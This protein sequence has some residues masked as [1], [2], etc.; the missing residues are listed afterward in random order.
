M[1]GCVLEIQYVNAETEYVAVTDE[2]VTGFDSNFAGAKELTI[3]YRHRTLKFTVTVNEKMFKEI[4]TAMDLY[5]IRYDLDGNYILMDDIDLTEAT[6]EGGEW[7]FEGRGWNPI[8]SNDVYSNNAFRGVFNGNGHSIKGMRINIEDLPAGTGKI[9]YAGL[10][11]NVTGEVKNLKLE[12]ANINVNTSAEVQV[13]V[14]TAST[15]NAVISSIDVSG[16]INVVAGYGN[17]SSK[18]DYI[19]VGGIAGYNISTIIQSKS[20]VKSNAKYYNGYTN[21]YVGGIAGYNGGNIQ[22]CY[23]EGDIKGEASTSYD[24]ADVGGVVG[25]NIGYISNCYNLADVVSSGRYPY[26][27]GIAGNSNANKISECYNIG[28]VKSKEATMTKAISNTQV[29]NCYYLQ[30]T[31]VSCT[32][33]TSLTETQMELQSVYVGFDF[34]NVWYID[35]KANYPYPQLIE[36]EKDIRVIKEAKIHSLPD[37]V[38]YTRGEELDVTGLQ[39]VFEYK[40]AETEYVTVTN[41]M[42]SG[43]SADTVG[44]QTLSTTYYDLVFNFEVTVN[45]KPFLEIY[46]VEDLYN[47][48]KD[49]S[50]NY[51]LMNDIDLTEATAKGGAWDFDGRGWNPIGSNDVYGNNAYSGIFDGNGYT[52]AGLRMDVTDLPSEIGTAIYCGLFAHVS[53]EVKN[54]NLQEFNI[55]IKISTTADFYVGALC[56]R[57]S[58]GAINCCNADVMINTIN[59]AASSYE[60]NYNNYVGGLV[61]YCSS[62]ITNSYTCGSL[63]VKTTNSSTAYS[64]AYAGGISG[65]G[66]N[67]Q[68]CYNT[69]D[70]TASAYYSRSYAGG[71]TARKIKAETIQNCY[72]TGLVTS[73]GDAYAISDGTVTNCYYLEG[74]GKGTTGTTA[75]TEAQMK[76][77][78]MYDGFDF[79]NVWVLNSHANYP[80]AQLCDNVQDLDETVKLIRVIAYPIQT[81]Y[82]TDDII[83]PTGGMFE[84]VYISGKTELLEITADMLS[85]YEP[86]TIGKQSITV[87]YGGQTDTFTINVSRRPEVTA[88]ELVSE[89]TQKDFVIGTAF[90]FSGAQV[91][92]SYDNNTSEI[93]NVTEDMTTGGDINHIDTYTITVNCGQQTV[94]FEVNVIPASISNIEIREL[95]TKLTY[96]EGE[97]FDATGMVVM[98]T[99]SNGSTVQI[100]S[101]YKVTGYLSEPGIHK[102]TIEFAGQKATFDVTVNERVLLN[103]E[104]KAKPDKLNY[105]VGE[106]LDLTGLLVVASYENGDLDIIEDYT[107]SGLDGKA[108]SKVITLTYKGKTAS[109]VVNVAVKCVEKIEIIK[110]PTKLSYIESEALNVEGMI[111]KATYNDGE[112]KTITDYKLEGYSSL[113]GVHTVYVS[114]EGQVDSFDVNVTEKVLSDLKV[115]IPTKTTYEIGETFDATGMVV[116]AYYNNGQQYS[117]DNYVMSEFDSNSAGAKEIKITYEGMTRSFVVTVVEKTPIETGGKIEVGTGKVRLGETISVPVTITKNT[118]LSAFCHTITFDANDLAFKKVNLQGGFANG[119]VIINDEKVANGEITILWFQANNVMESGIAYTLEFEVLETAT[120]GISDITIAFDANENGNASGENVLFEAVNGSVEVLSYWLGDLNGD[121]KYAMADLLQLAQYVSGQTMTLSDKQKLSA[122]V[123]EDG[124]IDIHDVTLLSQWLLEADM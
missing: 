61:G 81:E 91:K 50:A 20:N 74:T 68:N 90:D 47:V 105:V 13:G 58:N 65:Y 70:L 97:V 17:G 7:D 66:G 84:A 24:S 38:Q 39:L 2:M 46:T 116:T 10:F 103:L 48:R 52:I 57:T 118:G 67:I 56:G 110:M 120:D 98:A 29:A 30:G 100:K 22:Q 82:L 119:T 1:T 62:T 75:L 124:I 86:K 108:G 26:A 104:I 76:L 89:P 69:A 64:A 123:N 6:S 28:L 106:E 5:N 12:K 19:Y 41:D 101:G 99:Y 117:V 32:G 54:L 73:S 109:F 59:T 121:R 113:P 78:A 42:V 55:N 3:T 93:I 95:P 43:F 36:N 79:E 23:T 92:V 107:V 16:N 34:E 80:Y 27:G 122:D 4:H 11:A 31:G 21:V 33:A 85:G 63:N 25:S 15:S 37:K 44:K 114:Y 71:I 102:V 45:E 72:N 51:I 14:L 111:V 40:N 112:I 94:T 60:T 77:E 87:T 53:G 9:I 88:V 8:G 35:A 18:Y 96:M 49:L 83:D 115:T